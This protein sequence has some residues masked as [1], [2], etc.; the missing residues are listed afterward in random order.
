MSIYACG[1]FSS[2]WDYIYIDSPW[3][4]PFF[5]EQNNL[6]DFLSYTLKA[7]EKYEEWTVSVHE[8]GDVKNYHKHIDFEKDIRVMYY[9]GFSNYNFERKY[10]ESK[11]QKVSYDFFVDGN[12]NTLLECNVFTIYNNLSFYLDFEGVDDFI[13]VLQHATE[14]YVNNPNIKA[15]SAIDKLLK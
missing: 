7:K 10:K 11:P 8:A 3:A 6:N 12:G 4:T 15:D 2:L 1:I 14:R 13:Y 9:S 5:I